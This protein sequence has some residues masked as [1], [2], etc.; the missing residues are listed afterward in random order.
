MGK[1]KKI[2]D[3]S[4][5]TPLNLRHLLKPIP[6]IAKSVLLTI[7]VHLVSTKIGRTRRHSDLIYGHISVSRYQLHNISYTLNNISC[8][9]C[10]NWWRRGYTKFSAISASVFELSKD[11]W[12]EGSLHLTFDT[13]LPQDL[14]LAL[15]PS[16]RLSTAELCNPLIDGSVTG[17][18]CICLPSRLSFLASKIWVWSRDF[19]LLR[20]INFYPAVF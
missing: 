14:L 5:I 7:P 20:N 15:L 11:R 19:R 18:F 6:C 10:A 13:G 4:L 8:S 16:E 3:T 17:S 1:N 9:G 2:W 12:R